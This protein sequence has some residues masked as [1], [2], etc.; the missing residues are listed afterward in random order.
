MGG[1]PTLVYLCGTPSYGLLDV[2]GK[3]WDKSAHSYNMIGGN[4]ESG[5]CLVSSSVSSETTA[6]TQGVSSETT[7]SKST[8]GLS[9]K[10][11]NGKLL[12]PKGYYVLEELEEKPDFKNSEVTHQTCR[13][14]CSADLDCEGYDFTYSSPTNSGPGDSSTPSPT[15]GPNLNG[16][17]S[18]TSD[19][20]HSVASDS[21]TAH[22]VASDSQSTGHESS[23]SKSM[24]LIKKTCALITPNKP[25]S[26][27]E[28]GKTWKQVL[29]SDSESHTVAPSYGL[30]IVAVLGSS[31]DT[32]GNHYHSTAV[33]NKNTSTEVGPASSMSSSRPKTMTQ[34]FPKTLSR[35]LT[36]VFEY[37]ETVAIIVL[38]LGGFLAVS[39]L[40]TV[41]LMFSSRKRIRKN[42]DFESSIENSDSDPLFQAQSSEQVGLLG[43]A[44]QEM[45]R[46]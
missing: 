38:A 17:D 20:A 37:A 9:G 24:N 30:P 1:C 21:S 45:R 6:S 41:R 31:T 40:C 8:S 42:N 27:A 26:S 23:D 29:N 25:A 43:H 13:R 7:T 32:M 5:K 34:C 46:F 36:R 16:G 10:H 33:G 15:N 14:F 3:Y 18:S 19:S 11:S 22:S 44:S 35:A 39:I 2:Y 4:I 12:L 28:H